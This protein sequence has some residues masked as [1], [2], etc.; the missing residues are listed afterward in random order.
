MEH[1]LKSFKMEHDLKTINMEDNLKKI[2][3]KDSA[4]WVFPKWVKSNGHRKKREE[5]KVSVNNGQVN[6]WTNNV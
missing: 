6:V 3:M 4:S 1:D 5:E 2:R